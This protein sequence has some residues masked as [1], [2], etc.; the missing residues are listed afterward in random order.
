MNAESA[1]NT[2]DET[3]NVVRMLYHI[4]L[5]T[6]PTGTISGIRVLNAESAPNTNETVNVVMNVVSYLLEDISN[7]NN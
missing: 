4:H 7:W 3:V 2:T 5:K 1:P 6:F